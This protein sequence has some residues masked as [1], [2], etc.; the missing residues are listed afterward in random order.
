[1]IHQLQ[2]KIVLSATLPDVWDFFSNPA[3]LARITPPALNL[4]PLSPVEPRMYEGQI[5]VYRVKPFLQI[6]LTWVTEITHVREHDYFVDEQRLGPYRIWHHEHF[7]REVSEGV[8]V[9]D[10]V[11]YL[12]HGW[13]FGKVLNSMFIASRLRSIFAYREQAIRGIF[14]K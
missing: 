1:M 3:N 5:I 8:A 4:Q 13:A 10:R 6:P 11:S 9:E 2:S 14:E 7:F 12:L